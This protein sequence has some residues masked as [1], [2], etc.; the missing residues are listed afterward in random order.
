MIPQQPP[1]LWEALRRRVS[2]H[3]GQAVRQC[4]K[5]AGGQLRQRGLEG[6]QT[7]LGGAELAHQ[8]PKPAH[9]LRAGSGRV[10]GRVGGETVARLR[11]SH[12]ATDDPLNPNLARC[13]PSPHPVTGSFQPNTEH[14]WFF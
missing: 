10:G 1:H 5:A 12:T 9:H 2:A 8:D 6:Q 11:P 13:H 7:L 4:G 3:N 14:L